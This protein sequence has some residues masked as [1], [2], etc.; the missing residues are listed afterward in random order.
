[1][2][3]DSP[4]PVRASDHRPL[5]LRQKGYGFHMGR[6]DPTSDVSPVRASA[7]APDDDREIVERLK[8]VE[9]LLAAEPDGCWCGYCTKLNVEANALRKGVAALSAAEA[10]GRQ[11]AEQ[12]RPLLGM[13][14][15]Y[16]LMD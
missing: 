16:E 8:E 14:R 3:D 7:Q 1:M 9:E 15:I 10:R 13:M 12:E 2:S 4:S 6:P 5:W 11:Q